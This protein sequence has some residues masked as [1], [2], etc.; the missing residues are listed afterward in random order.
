[1]VEVG[2]PH[3]VF[4][5]LNV[6]HSKEQCG[7]CGLEMSK[8]CQWEIGIR[9]SIPNKE[10]EVLTKDLFHKKSKVTLKRGY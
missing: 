1:M 3:L 5:L 10:K 9:D 6:G 8:E 7:N 2:S 4:F